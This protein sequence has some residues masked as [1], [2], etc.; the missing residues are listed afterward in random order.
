MEY[1]KINAAGVAPE[2]DSEA[3]ELSPISAGARLR[4]EPLRVVD[5]A[6]A[7]IT[8]AELARVIAQSLSSLRVYVVESD[9][10]D[11]Q[12]SVKAVVDQATF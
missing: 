11:A 1:P 4:D 7:Q 2:N 9:I 6:G 8:V 12:N 10:T 5:Q 3:M